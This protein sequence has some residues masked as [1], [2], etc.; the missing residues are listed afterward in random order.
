MRDA[1]G[2]QGTPRR[3]GEL[4]AIFLGVA[5]TA[6]VYGWTLFTVNPR[7]SDRTALDHY[8]YLTDALL[9]GQLHLKIQPDPQLAQ[10]DN[11]YAGSQ[12]IPTLHDATYFNGQYFLYFGPAPVLL[13]LGPWRLLTGTFLF[14]GV[15]TVAFSFV[16]FLIGTAL[17]VGWKR[18]F[19]PGLPDFW[20]GFSIVMLGLGNYV[21][22]LIQTP[23][24]YEVPISCAYACL[25]GALAAVVAA[26][27]AEGVGR[28]SL[29]LGLASLLLGLAV[30]SRPDYL[31]ALPALGLPLAV[32][33]MQARRRE[34]PG[35][36]DCRRLAVAAIAPAGAVGI[37]LAAYNWARFG[38]YLEFG[39]K[40]QLAS[41]DQRE[42]KLSSLSYIPGGL[43]SF[44]WNPPHYFSH[45]PFLSESADS[46]GVVPWAPFA[47]A[48]LAFPLTFL[49]PARR[50]RLW[51]YGGGFL[52]L[53]A[54]LNF[55]ALSMIAF[56]NDRYAID[57]LPAATWL[58]LVVMAVALTAGRLLWR[59]CGFMLALVASFTLLH[60]LLLGLSLR[61]HSSLAGALNVPAAALER[62]T[63]VRY[64]PLQLKVRFPDKPVEGRSE[65]LLSMAD[66][67][68]L[69]YEIQPDAAHVQF[70]FFHRG[71]GG[72]VSDPVSLGTEGVHDLNLDL[73][74][75][76]PPSDHPLFAG[77]PENLVDALH[78]RLAVSIDGR[79]VLDRSV[80]FYT[81]DYY[82]T[83]VGAGVRTPDGVVPF[84]GAVVSAQ[85]GQIPP[86]SQVAPLPVY[87]P[88]RITLRFP[89]FTAVFG[90]PLISTGRSGAGDL[91]YVTYLAPG[92]VRFGHDCWNHGSVETE[93]VAFD[94]SREQTVEVDMGSISRAPKTS[95][96]GSTL[97]QLSF[98]GRVL[99]SAYRP[100]HPTEPVD[101]V[102]GYNAIHAST[103]AA[104][105]TGP[106]FRPQSVAP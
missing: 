79:T 50:S 81:N 63:G 36:P 15:A 84:S 3:R 77:W 12:G 89:E 82:H 52:L 46:F 26:L 45:F 39:V 90:E 92:L 71:I 34:G 58:G 100:F 80:E 41:Q 96:D 29:M 37:V 68:D 75:L 64:G 42:M 85:R 22:F 72:P 49:D 35:G 20:T 83:T 76:Y 9:S 104:S 59:L 16:G 53:A 18:R 69:L 2:D 25:M 94:P 66:G 8:G 98:N 56:R 87:G 11:P 13:L 101:V 43:H 60:C 55:L 88:I 61:P 7:F 14:E 106:E 67:A 19:L 30:G 105:F 97:F 95:A 1:A 57:F 51:I 73:G 102:F 10:L 31:F 17:W 40:Y 24:F 65:A 33:W 38:D 23:M 70:R 74:A 27:K 21:F 6:A 78:R 48:A 103:A 47:L 93:P 32:L 62:M 5:L 28:Q 91:V 86:P 54:L 4:I 99:E 44:L